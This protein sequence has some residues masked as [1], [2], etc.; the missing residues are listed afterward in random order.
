MPI[1]NASRLRALSAKA[2]MGPPKVIIPRLGDVL[3][4]GGIEGRASKVKAMPKARPDG[5]DLVQVV[6]LM[7]KPDLY[8]RDG[9]RGFTQ[10]FAMTSMQRAEKRGQ[11]V[12][13]PE[14]FESPLQRFQKTGPRF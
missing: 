14:S 12:N 2:R 1:A 10:A 4:F 7:A 6:T 9:M 5:G 11:F 13:N 8:A 3:F